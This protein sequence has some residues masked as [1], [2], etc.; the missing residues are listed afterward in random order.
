MTQ[1]SEMTHAA[2]L[3]MLVGAG[4]LAVILRSHEAAELQTSSIKIESQASIEGHIAVISV[5]VK[6][7]VLSFTVPHDEAVVS[8]PDTASARKEYVPDWLQHPLELGDEGLEANLVQDDSIVVHAIW[9]PGFEATSVEIENLCEEHVAEL[10]RED[11]KRKHLARKSFAEKTVP[12]LW[13]ADLIRLPESWIEPLLAHPGWEFK[14]L[15]VQCHLGV[16]S[17][18][19]DAI[20]IL[21][22]MVLYI[23]NESQRQ[24]CPVYTKRLKWIYQEQ[25][26]RLD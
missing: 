18:D 6:S 23:L 3:L 9:S 4:M 22:L 24:S 17:N 12:S 7:K 15:C 21:R 16:F 5:H 26:N 11:G 2:S 20:Q 19:F 10:Q 1:A 8:I 25:V 13:R 14:K